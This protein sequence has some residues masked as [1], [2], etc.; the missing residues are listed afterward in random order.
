MKI[1]NKNLIALALAGAL[2]T[3]FAI[4]AAESTNP[5]P[6]PQMQAQMQT[7]L[8]A[9]QVRM[10]ALQATTDPQVRMTLMQ[11]QLNDMQTQMHDMGAVGPMMSGGA[12]GQTGTGMMGTGQGNMGSGAMGG[13]QGSMG[14]GSMGVARNQWAVDLWAAAR[15]Q[16]AVDLWVVA[17]DQ[18]AV[19]P[20]AVAR[21]QCT[22]NKART[23]R[24]RAPWGWPLGRMCNPPPANDTQTAEAEP[25]S[26]VPR[27]MVPRCSDEAYF[28]EEWLCPVPGCR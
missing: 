16:W 20:W 7:R 19:D 28:A 2:A 5:L 15:D 24:V 9:M 23:H 17:R 11:A 21:D 3:P 26:L 4:L 8:Q 14:G 10:Q 13:A 22:N 12:M 27:N 25:G 18:W 6:T 1:A